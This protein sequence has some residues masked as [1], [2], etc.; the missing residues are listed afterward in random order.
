MGS[1]LLLSVA[2]DPLVHS[3]AAGTGCVTERKT[4]GVSALRIATTGRQRRHARIAVR[5]GGGAGGAVR[6]TGVAEDSVHAP[7]ARAVQSTF[8]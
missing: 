7:F 2:K 4:T 5:G 8:T 6:C 3:L 1:S